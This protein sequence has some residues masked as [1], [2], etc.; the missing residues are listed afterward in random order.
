[1]PLMWG[2][3]SD[4]GSFPRRSPWLF[5]FIHEGRGAARGLRWPSAVGPMR[6][7]LTG[8]MGFALKG[9]KLLSGWAPPV[10][11][12]TREDAAA[13]SGPPDG[14]P[15]LGPSS[16]YS[17]AQAGEARRRRSCDDEGAESPRQKRER[18]GGGSLG[19]EAASALSC[20]AFR[21]R[22]A[23]TPELSGR[24][25]IAG[26]VSVTNGDIDLGCRARRGKDTK[27]VRP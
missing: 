10:G 1:M 26:Q 16:L 20:P 14:G 8:P 24:A 13:S 11:R 25:A 9:Q 2:R 12:A 27:I 23:K 18:A 22:Q 3:W 15:A 7:E 6:S 21:A 4:P 5:F 17:A 19:V